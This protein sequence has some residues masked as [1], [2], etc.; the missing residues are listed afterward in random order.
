MPK[1]VMIYDPKWVRNNP[2]DLNELGTKLARKVAELFSTDQVKL[3]PKVDIDFILQPLV[4]GSIAPH[5]S[6]EIEAIGYPE[7]KARL[8][9]GVMTNMKESFINI[10]TLHRSLPMIDASKPLIW[11]KYTD[12]DGYHV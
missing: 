2:D 3:D 7:R 11:V 5:I 6:F 1:I 4:A 9:A 8:T 10:M 12:P